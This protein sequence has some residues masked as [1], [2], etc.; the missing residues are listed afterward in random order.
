M[1]FH[2]DKAPLGPAIAQES[3]RAS[4]IVDARMTEVHANM[5]AV[6]EGIASLAVQHDL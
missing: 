2:P 3:E 4:E 6:I 5:R 1:V